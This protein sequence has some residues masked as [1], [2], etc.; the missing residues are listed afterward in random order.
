MNVGTAVKAC[1][2]A[3][4]VPHSRGCCSLALLKSSPS[5]CELWDHISFI[6]R[7]ERISES[8]LF[9]LF[10]KHLK[11][12]IENILWLYV[13]VGHSDDFFIVM[14][15][16]ESHSFIWC[17]SNNN[18]VPGTLLDIRDIEN[19]FFK[20]L[21]NSLSVFL[22]IR[23]TWLYLTHFIFPS[24]STSQLLCFPILS[25]FSFMEMS[26]TRRCL[27]RNVKG[28]VCFLFWPYAIH[29]MG[30]SI[31]HLGHTQYM[32]WLCLT[33]T[34]GSLPALLLFIFQCKISVV[35]LI[36]SQMYSF[37]LILSES[38]GSQGG[39]IW[40]KCSEFPVMS[41]DSSS[42]MLLL[43]PCGEQCL[44]DHYFPAEGTSWDSIWEA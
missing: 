22:F 6:L 40:G 18:H 36:M 25:T 14:F 35:W 19:K 13:P 41:L 2:Q 30:T 5:L 8:T 34:F 12:N 33:V 24:T 42:M 23:A 3:W 10:L 16:F 11:K 17:V 39:S 4:N 9:K 26:P 20:I 38:L 29:H 37:G 28:Q 32:I 43:T 27:E 7:L 44:L 21:Y 31:F 15:T 1:S